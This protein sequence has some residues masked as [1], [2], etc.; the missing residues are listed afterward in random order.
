MPD[1]GGKDQPFHRHSPQGVRAV[2]QH[3]LLAAA[4]GFLQGVTHAGRVGVKARADVRQIADQDIDVFHLLGGRAFRLAIKTVHRDFRAR[5]HRIGDRRAVFHLS[6]QPMLR[7]EHRH[8]GHARGLHQQVHQG[9]SVA[10]LGRVV[11]EN[12]H[13]FSQQ[14]SEILFL[15]NIQPGLDLGAE[16]PRQQEDR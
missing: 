16:N 11:D 10:V 3:E 6:R 15:Q 8:Q 13:P 12:P 2:E 14:G 5:V 4:G 9:A 7:G 1:L